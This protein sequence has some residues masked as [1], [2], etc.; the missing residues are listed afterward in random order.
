MF[1]FFVST[2]PP[3]DF[4]PLFVVVVTAEFETVKGGRL[5][6]ID[7][8]ESFPFEFFRVELKLEDY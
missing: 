1:D 8:P 5:V 6:E 3:V 4:R 2:I 7:R